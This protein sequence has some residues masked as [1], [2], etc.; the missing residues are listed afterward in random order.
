MS[1]WITDQLIEW[2]KRFI[3]H[4]FTDMREWCAPEYEPLILVEGQGVLL[5]SIA[6]VWQ[7]SVVA[8]GKNAEEVTA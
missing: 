2:D 7:R 5:R 1:E 6:E 3:W 8:A 4:P